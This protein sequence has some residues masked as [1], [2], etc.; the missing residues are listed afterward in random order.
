MA[1]K[2]TI[3]N[4]V[5]KFK[6]DLLDSLKRNNGNLN[7]RSFV[8]LIKEMKCYYEEVEGEGKGRDRVIYTD[9]K[10]KE[11]AKKEDKRQFNKGAAPPHSKH[12]AFMVMSKMDDIDS[13]ARTRNDWATYLRLMSP[14]ERDI[15]K[16]IYNVEVL[17][18]Y[19]EFMITLGIMEDGEENVFQ[20]LADTLKNVAKGQVQTVLKQVEEMKLISII[21]SWKGKV[22]DSKES[23]DIDKAMA[24]EINNTEAELLKKHGINKWEALNLKNSPRTK[25]FNAEWLEYIE[26]VEDDEGDAMQLQY[27]YELFQIEV[28]NKNALA[29]YIKAHYPTEIDSFNILKNEQEYQSK[30]LDYVVE[31]AKKKHNNY[32]MK[33]KGKK[34]QNEEDLKGVMISVG[35]SEEEATAFVRQQ[36]EE[37]NLNE[38]E[39][40]PYITL[41]ESDKYVDCIR[42]I[43]IQL[44]GMIEVEI[45]EIK[46][47]QKK[48]DEYLRKKLG[49]LE[50]SLPAKAGHEKSVKNGIRN[51][52]ESSKNAIE[53][54]EELTKKVKIK[55]QEVNQAAKVAVLENQEQKDNIFIGDPFVDPS[56]HYSEKE[57]NYHTAMLDIED[58]IRAYKEKYGDKAMEHM[59]LDAVFREQEMEVTVEKMIAEFK[60]QLECEK[61]R[62]RK[63]WDKL[64][65]GGQPVKRELTTNDPLEV[66]ERIRY[67]R[68]DKE[69]S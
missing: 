49:K 29:E 14:A 35:L 55:Q 50:L 47:V 1:K 31:N 23:I 36:E 53:Q 5:K 2:W 25:A 27:I 15:M 20:D 17:K 69:D 43:H 58:E 22:K 45:E 61:E 66:F 13:K 56:M 38:K 41:L 16:G 4:A 39:P 6:P 12:L 59:K 54:Q 64:F 57:H 34:I 37:V 33:K 62:E 21:S 68:I 11:K 44:H 60:Q 51:N 46:A 19:K 3:Q 42:N 24:N 26:N 10:R 30:L 9:K 40:S 67:G 65:E 63:E 28:L 18:P 7:K 48:K 52:D 8:S 32:L